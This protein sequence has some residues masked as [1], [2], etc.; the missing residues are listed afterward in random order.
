M[1]MLASS[2]LYVRSTHHLRLFAPYNNNDIIKFAGYNFLYSYKM[3][4]I[5]LIDSALQV[6][7][8]TYKSEEARFAKVSLFEDNRLV[9]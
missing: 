3:A 9:S 6:I 8:A 5:V 7:N 4:W 2:W 1:S